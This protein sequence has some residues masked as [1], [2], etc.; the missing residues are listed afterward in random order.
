MNTEL[1][2]HKEYYTQNWLLIP[3]MFGDVSCC[4]ISAKTIKIDNCFTWLEFI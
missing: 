3:D 1:Y 4:L 2:A